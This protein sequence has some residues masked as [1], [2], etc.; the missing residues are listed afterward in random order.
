MKAQL[1]PC[2]Y[3][4]AMLIPSLV[5]ALVNPSAVEQCP[6][7]PKAERRIDAQVRSEVVAGELD[8]WR[9]LAYALAAGAA[10]H[11]LRG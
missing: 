2:P 9:L 10:D 4:G 7:Q 3:C 5:A 1:V 6:T 11:R 8:A